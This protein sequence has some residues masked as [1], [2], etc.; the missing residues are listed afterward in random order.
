MSRSKNFKIFLSSLPSPLKKDK[1]KKLKT[2][3]KD[4]A[5]LNGVGYEVVG[6]GK[7]VVTIR[8]GFTRPVLFLMESCFLFKPRL[9]PRT[10]KHDSVLA[11]DLKQKETK[12]MGED[13]VLL[14]NP[15]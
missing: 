10:Y 5:D 3:Q 13:H 12:I 14:I 1:L 7:E 6:K 2:H 8:D 11:T 15:G 9:E 4:V